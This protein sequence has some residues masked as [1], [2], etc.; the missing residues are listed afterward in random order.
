MGD[1]AYLTPNGSMIVRKDDNV[2][3]V[4]AAKLPVQFSKLRL[5]PADVASSV[6]MTILGCWKG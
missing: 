1:G 4:D 5:S 6:A 3:D 2:L